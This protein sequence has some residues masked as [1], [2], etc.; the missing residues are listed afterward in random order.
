M[1]VMRMM[2][3]GRLH[4]PKLR[5]GYRRNND[6]ASGQLESGLLLSLTL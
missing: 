2:L 3:D 1:F 4:T 6:A 5:V